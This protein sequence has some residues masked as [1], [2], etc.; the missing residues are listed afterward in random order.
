MMKFCILSTLDNPT[1]V[2]EG[3]NTMKQGGFVVL[4]R[5]NR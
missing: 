3:I 2:A 4:G 1:W 5:A